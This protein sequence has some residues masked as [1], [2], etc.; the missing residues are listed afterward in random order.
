MPSDPEEIPA[1][2]ERFPDIDLMVKP[3]FLL[4]VPTVARARPWIPLTPG[5]FLCS[6]TKER[7][8]SWGPREESTVNAQS[9]S[10]LAKFLEVSVASLWA[11]PGVTLPSMQEQNQV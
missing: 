8:G 10:G 5:L 11:A 1:Q 4:K 3:S 7:R 2:P 6:Q 9:H